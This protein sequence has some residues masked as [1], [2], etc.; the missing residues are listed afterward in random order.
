MA[1]WAQEV[2]AL[3]RRWFIMLRR[4]RLGLVFSLLQ[5]AIWLVFF[6]LGMGRA[7]DARTVGTADYLSFVLPGIIA[8]TVMGN[9]VGSAM[10]LLFDKEDGY[11]EKLMAMPISRSSVIVSR[12]LYQT[13]LLAGQVVLLL[14]V[15]FAMGVRLAAGP[16]GFAVL[17]LAVAL[18]TLAVTAAFLAL[19][20]AVPGHGT[21]FAITGFA[22]L[23]VL[24]I[25]NAFVPLD[26]MPAWMAAI[27]RVNPLSWAIASMRIVVLDGWT[28]ELPVALGVLATAAAA[29]LA[30]GTW[31]FRRHTG[32]RVG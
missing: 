16:A 22:T 11:L 15:A 24:F 13:V 14:A 32:G 10:P 31:E 20:Y 27:A 12:F 7:I 19:A 2:L 29:L 23:P 5:P 4:E 3:A 26:A 9:G 17:L 6:G 25:S 30:C 8:F 18:L 28:A 21:F 1:A